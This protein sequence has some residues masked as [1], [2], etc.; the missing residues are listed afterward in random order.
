MTPPP[1]PLCDIQARYRSL[2]D[3]IDAAVLRVLGSG[4]AILGPEVAAFEEEAAKA[5]GAA[6]A[7]GC[8]SGTD[9][10]VLA[11]HALGIGPGDEVIVPPFTFFA[12]ASTVCRVGARPVFADIDPVT[13][14][15][16]PTQVEAKITARTRA[17]VPV[18]LFGQCCDMDAIGRIAEANSLYVV[19]DAAQSQGAEYRGRPCGTLGH[20]SCFS[21]YPTKNLGALG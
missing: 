13:Y 15:L 4:Q 8:S 21:F 7:I 2:K 18:H 16:D 1:V 20:V 12:T 9:A 11:L 19:E 6:H 14:N 10:L 3:E 17:V 5:V